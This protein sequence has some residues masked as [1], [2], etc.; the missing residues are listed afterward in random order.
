MRGRISGSRWRHRG[1]VSRTRS[2][3]EKK[4]KSGGQF[5]RRKVDGDGAKPNRMW[6]RGRESN[7]YAPYGAQD[8]KFVHAP[9]TIEHYRAATQSIQAFRPYC[10]STFP[11][12]VCRPHSIVWTK[13][14]QSRTAQ[15]GATHWIEHPERRCKPLKTK[16]ASAHFVR[17][18][19]VFSLRGRC[20]SIPRMQT[21]GRPVPFPVPFCPG[22]GIA[23]PTA[24]VFI[25]IARRCD[26][27][28]FEVGI[29]TRATRRDCAGSPKH[30]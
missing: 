24:C 6:C 11:S 14:G 8:F 4:G 2:D 27:G 18:L 10:A 28:I 21:D 5:G 29:S 7:P 16:T 19:S 26:R 1:P 17:S 15:I 3:R 22:S 12:V 23:S 13:F 9:G 25:C 20:L 30:S